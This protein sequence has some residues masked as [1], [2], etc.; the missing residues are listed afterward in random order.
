MALLEIRNV[1]R[2]FGDFVAVD[3]V[4]LS[5]EA[6]EFFCLLGPSGCGKTTLLRMIAGFDATDGGSIW[7][8]GR[9]MTG[10]PPEGRNV[11]TVFQSYA[12]FPHMTVAENIAF[13]LKMAGSRR[14]KSRRARGGARGCVSGRDERAHPNALSGGQRQRVAVAR[15]LVN[16]PKLLL[17]DEPLAALDAKLRR[18]CS[19][20]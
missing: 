14:P 9:D 20:S 12:L 1:T 17:L 7:L 2:R 15:A 4:S 19:S 5:V 13:P 18:R 10:I 6:G 8:D 16:R 3:D 11:H